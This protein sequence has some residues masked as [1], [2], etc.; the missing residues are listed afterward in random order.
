MMERET[1]E[2]LVRMRGITKRFAGV[3]ANLGVDFDLN[4]GEVHA[5]LGENGAGKST[6]MNILYGLYHPDSGS[7]TVRGREAAFSSPRDAIAAGIGMVHQHFM[8]IP[9]QTV[10]ENMVLGLEGLSPVLPKK[11]IKSQISCLSNQYG[12][13]VNPDAM[14]WQLSIGEQ[15][16]VAILKMLYRKARILILDEPTAVLTPQEAE[17]LFSTIRQMTREGHGVVFIS[18]KLDEVMRLSSRVTILRKGELAGT[19]DPSGISKEKLAE[20]MIGRKVIFQIEKKP[21][22]PG[23][24]VLQCECLSVLGDRGLPS[25]SSVSLSLNEREILGIA[26]VAGNGQEELCETF[27]GLRRAVSGSVRVNG[28]DLTNASAKTFIDSGIRYI[29]AD[30]R[31]TGLVTGMDVSENSILKR[32][33]NPPVARGLFIDW[34][35]AAAFARDLVSRFSVSTPSLETPV[36]NLSGGNL[37]KL[38]LGREL[39]DSPKAVL[40]VHP[41]WG[42]DVAA[43]KFVREQLLVQRERGCGV[44]LVS[45]DLEELLSLCDRLAV[46]C[47]GKIMGILE[48]PAGAKLE[49]IGL[50]MAGVPLHDIPQ[51]EREGELS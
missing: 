11:A 29:P 3:T 9:G 34:K 16:R 30:R 24:E 13:E 28:R 31:G 27:A 48:N 10:W 37:Q 18:H 38:M 19:V 25:V 1:P 42:L 47:K 22:T 35:E 15:Q 49:V 4:S 8:L 43:T 23:K 21:L 26:G 51:G 45:E 40:A 20:L 41:T 7:I 5:L 6:L 44:L 33:W 17:S 32:Y 36:K 50:M 12:L 46:M 14:I 39:S 2:V